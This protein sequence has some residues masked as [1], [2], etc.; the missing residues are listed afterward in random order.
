MQ[1]TSCSIERCLARA[2]V[3][4]MRLIHRVEVRNLARELRALR[5]QLPG[6]GREAFRFHRVRGN[7]AVHALT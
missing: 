4:L 1:A 3:S 6:E 5:R 2:R 7:L